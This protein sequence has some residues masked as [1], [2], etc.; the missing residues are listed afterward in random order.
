MA[1]LVV[2]LESLLKML[3]GAGKVAEIK[4]GLAENAVCDHCLGAIR[5]SCGLSQEQL[6]H[7]A[8]RLGLAASQMPRPKTVIGGE[9]LRGVFHLVCQFVGARKGP[10]GF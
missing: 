6:R 8:H 7:L 4:T 3:M 1:R 10:G 9:P 2:E 5:P